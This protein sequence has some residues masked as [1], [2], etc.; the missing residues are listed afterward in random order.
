[1]FLLRHTGNDKDFLVDARHL[2]ASTSR[3]RA[4]T[5]RPPA[6]PRSSPSHFAVPEPALA[7]SATWRWPAASTIEL[8]H[9][10]GYLYKEGEILSPDGHCRA[11]DHRAQG[12][13]FGSGAGVVVLRRLADALADGDHIYAV[14]KGT[15]VNNDGAARSAISRRASTARPRRSPRR[16]AVAG[17]AADTHRLRRMP[18]HR[19][20]PRRP[21][22]GRGADRRRSARRTER[23]RLLPHRLGQDQHRPPRHRRRRREPDQGGA[24][25][26]APRR[27]RRASNFEAPN[28]AIDFAREPVPR[29]RPRCADW[30]RGDAPRRA[31]VNSLG[32]GGTNA[33]VVLEEAPARGRVRACELAVPAARRSRRAIARGARRQRRSGSP[34]TC[35]S[36]PSS[37]SPTSPTR[38]K[39]GPARLRAAPRASPPRPRGGRG[40]ARERRPAARLHAQRA[41]AT[42]PRSCSCSRAAARSTPAWRAT[43][44]RPSRCS[45]SWSTAASRCCSRGSTT[46]S[47]PL[48]LPDAR[49]RGRGGRAA[50]AAVGAAAADLHRRVRAGAAA[51]CRG[52][53][54]PPR[55][56]ATAWAR[57]PP[58]ASPA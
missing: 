43:C 22:R 54:S 57:T 31:A 17:V 26:R 42:R 44:T 48:W 27:S 21:D 29:Q 53:S 30:P 35:A 52:A 7:A 4:S 18:R 1:M 47:A 15:A 10:R 2:R 56:S 6:R 51:G 20:V 24:G 38:C 58:P 8:P 25:A 40:A 19:H 12:T 14:I 3:A 5:C 11:F 39:A 36:I 45:A 49:A 41:S 46:T 32:V 37:R 33:H 16:I 34:R 55:W 13:V 50:E 28:P 23:T 9:G